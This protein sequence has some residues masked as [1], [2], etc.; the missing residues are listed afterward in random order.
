MSFASVAFPDKL[1][2]GLA[3]ERLG[4]S[5]VTYRLGAFRA[6]DDMAAA[7]RRIE[8]GRKV[9]AQAHR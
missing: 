3:V 8:L 4:R 6:G 1:D 2:V 9:F 5:S 7:Q